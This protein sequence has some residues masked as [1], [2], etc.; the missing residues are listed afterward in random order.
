MVFNPF[1]VNTDVAFDEVESRMLQKTSNG[2][3]ANIEPIH[4]VMI[5]LQQAF[6]QMI[7]NEAINAEDQH[8]CTTFSGGN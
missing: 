7:T 4:F 6:G 5:F 2:V 3:T 1:G 8:A